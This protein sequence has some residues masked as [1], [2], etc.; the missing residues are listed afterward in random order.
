M[1]SRSGTRGVSINP[2]GVRELDAFLRDQI[3]RED[4]NPAKR[5]LRQGTKV[6]ATNDLIPELQKAAAG[7]GVPIAPAMAATARTRTDRIVTVRIGAV[8]PKGLR[9]FKRGRGEG[10]AT[11]S[12]YRTRNSQS[13][14][15]TLAYGSDR[16][17]HPS[18]TRSNP[19]GVPRNEGGYWVAPGVAAA[20]DRVKS[21]YSDLLG[22]ILRDYGRYR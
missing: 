6:I 12:G 3:A 16:G 15:T 7:S 1:G 21:A 18:N 2:R 4:L 19:Y 20:F 8:N 22:Q 9:G 5:Q 17:P 14:R 11:T 10:K 13:D